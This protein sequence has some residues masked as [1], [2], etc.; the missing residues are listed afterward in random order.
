MPG[1][2][3]QI[4]LHARRVVLRDDLA[5]A[6]RVEVVDRHAV[7][8]R[9][10]P[11]TLR[12]VQTQIFHPAAGRDPV[13]QRIQRRRRR[14]KGCRQHGLQF[15]GNAIADPVDDGVKGTMAHSKGQRIDF[16]FGRRS[17]RLDFALEPDVGRLGQRPTE[18]G[19]TGPDHFGAIGA[20]DPDQQ[21]V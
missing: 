5:V 19:R 18:Q 21:G 13:S 16:A 17:E 4:G 12:S 3:A 20:H 15:D 1:S 6:V 9:E 11:Q 8:S 2:A 10:R 14:P 7:E